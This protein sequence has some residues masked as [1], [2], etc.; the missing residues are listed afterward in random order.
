M[1]V[2]DCFLV[3]LSLHFQEEG[4]TC[5]FSLQKGGGGGGGGGGLVGERTN[6]DEAE[7]RLLRFL[8]SSLPPSLPCLPL[9]LTNR[10]FT[11]QTKRN[12]RSNLPPL[13]Y[14]GNKSKSIH[15]RLQPHSREAMPMAHS[16]S[17]YQQQEDEEGEEEEEEPQQLKNPTKSE[18][19]Q[20]R[21]NLHC[22]R[23]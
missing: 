13:F 11:N 9:R 6:D 22:R 12:G 20:E 23:K 17:Q 2:K 7:K 4:Q 15:A 8:P 18:F 16:H 19:E 3:P 5:A 10:E 1:R 21:D 14:K